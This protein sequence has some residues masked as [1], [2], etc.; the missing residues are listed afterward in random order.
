MS[1][2]KTPKVYT[3]IFV[4]VG[5]WYVETL[6]NP[7]QIIWRFLRF[8]RCQMLQ[9]VQTFKLNVWFM[10]CFYIMQSWWKLFVL[11]F[12]L[13]AEKK[14]DAK[15]L[16]HIHISSFFRQCEIEAG[17]LQTLLEKRKKIFNITVTSEIGSFIENDV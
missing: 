15:F 14:I 13:Q 3:L 1:W 11:Y 17:V 2:L 6:P 5:M 16:A 12:N 7:I 9:Q 10:F 4:C 8:L